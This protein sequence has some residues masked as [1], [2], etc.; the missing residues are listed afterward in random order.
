MTTP[1]LT[2][3]VTAE[4]EALHVEFE[5]WFG[6]QS[7][8]F[9]RI[10]TSMADDF[11]FVSPSGDIIERRELLAGLRAS[12][13]SRQVPIRIENVAVRWSS[14]SEVLATYEEW[15]DHSGHTSAR[16]STV[17]FTEDETAPGGLLWRH[18]HETWKVPPPTRASR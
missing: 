13:D 18:V 15:Q 5:R 3:R 17:L 11:T 8:D 4:V 7:D 6:G 12:H 10:E 1:S 9:E 2:R 16:Q 14:D